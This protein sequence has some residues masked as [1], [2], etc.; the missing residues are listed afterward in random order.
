MKGRVAGEG[1][2]VTKAG[3]VEEYS[4]GED[5]RSQD[6]PDYATRPKGR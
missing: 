2:G 5:M 1:G 3:R 4:L 6:G